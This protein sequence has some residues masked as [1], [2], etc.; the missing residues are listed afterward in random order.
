MFAPSHGHGHPCVAVDLNTQLDF[1]H[2]SGLRPVANLP[3]FLR[4][5]QRVVDWIHR[6]GAPVASSVE[7]HRITEVPPDGRPLCCVDGSPGQEKIPLTLFDSRCWVEVDNTLS[8]P[9]DL[10]RQYRQIIFRKRSDDLLANPKADRFFT[11]VRADEFIVFGVSVEAAVKTLVLGLL[12][13]GRRVT[14][15]ADACGFWH[16]NC[17]EMAMRQMAA[18]GAEL[19]SSER[20]A[21]RRTGFVS[22]P[23]NGRERVSDSPVLRVTDPEGASRRNDPNGR[24]ESTLPRTRSHAKLSGPAKRSRGRRR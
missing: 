10:F 1:C 6:T 14:V 4:G 12:A 3:G 20:L 17:A 22:V 9:T 21:R 8:C 15:V 18:K 11:Q 19:I 13:R 7:S 2:G 5:L 23:P 16:G 24:S